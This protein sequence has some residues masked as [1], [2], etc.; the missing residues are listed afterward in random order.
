VQRSRKASTRE[1]GVALIRAEAALDQST[2]PTRTRPNP[3]RSGIAVPAARLIAD[4]AGA[5]GDIFKT[6]ILTRHAL[7]LQN[8]ASIA[9]TVITAESAFVEEPDLAHGVDFLRPPAEAGEPSS[10]AR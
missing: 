3:D 9:A 5:E 7:A 6:G 10:V 1:E 8:A 2:S 4:N